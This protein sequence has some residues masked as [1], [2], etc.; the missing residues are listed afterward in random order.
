MCIARIYRKYRSVINYLIFGVLT[1]AVNLAVYYGLICTCL[2]PGDTFE[3]Q[4]AVVISWIAAVT[5]AY[6]TNRKY[7][8]EKSGKSIWLECLSFYIARIGTLFLEMALMFILVSI[9]GINDKASKLFV[10]MLVIA[11]NYFL[12]KM[13]VFGKNEK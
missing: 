5:F 4:A 3:L 13:F 8:F 2:D 7:V 12:S 1:T 11:A 6:I 10:Q 9:L